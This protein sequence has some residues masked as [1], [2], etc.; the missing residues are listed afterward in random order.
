M[1]LA[2]TPEY[3][4]NWYLQRRPL[5]ECGAFCSPNY[6]RCRECWKR[7]LSASATGRSI[8]AV[9]GAKRRYKIRK[10]EEHLAA[11]PPDR[12]R[13]C[14]QSRPAGTRCPECNRAKENRGRARKAAAGGSH[15]VAQWLAVVQRQ[16]GACTHCK[17]I[18]PLTRDHVIPVSRGGSDDIQNIQALC[19]PC[20][21]R[22]CNRL[23]M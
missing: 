23:E 11:N 2:K 21:S 4:R 9:R 19:R 15:T 20:N 14:G 8:E 6:T 13:Q 17:A 12:C 10:R 16:G 7:Q 1:A 18:A 3:K 5:C 22:K